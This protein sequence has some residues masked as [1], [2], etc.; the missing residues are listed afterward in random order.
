MI[1]NI[2][3]LVFYATQTILNNKKN[4]ETISRLYHNPNGRLKPYF[5]SKIAKL[6]MPPPSL[7]IT[8][9]YPRNLEK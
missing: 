3:M 2:T 1:Q 9:T 6:P 5:P 7:I 8:R 4:E